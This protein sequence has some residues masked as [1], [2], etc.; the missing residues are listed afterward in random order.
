M[1]D[2]ITVLDSEVRCGSELYILSEKKL[3]ERIELMKFGGFEESSLKNLKIVHK[4]GNSAIRRQLTNLGLPLEDFDNMLVLADHKRE[5]NPLDSDAHNLATMLLIRDILSENR[6]NTKKEEDAP[7]R[8]TTVR[9]EETITPMRPMTPKD[10]FKARVSETITMN[11][12]LNTLV[13]QA[14]IHRW[15]LMQLHRVEEETDKKPCI[16]CCE[17]LDSRTKNTLLMNQRVAKE[18]EYILSHTTVAKVISMVA[19]RREIK[20]VLEE[21]LGEYGQSIYVMP[22]SRYV[23]TDKPLSFWDLS[24]KASANNDILIGYQLVSQR[25]PLVLNPEKK[26]TPIRWG[27][28]DCVIIICETTSLYRKNAADPNGLDFRSPVRPRYTKT[29]TDRYVYGRKD[30]SLSMVLSDENGDV[31]DDV[32]D[33]G[34]DI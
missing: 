29:E 4:F 32:M 9:W 13:H 7:A 21:L 10:R 26:E 33:T 23:K 14:M 11:R 25:G 5:I 6:Y 30:K 16:I 19:M 24:L 1:E 2:I 15:N 27:R 3:D 18:A 17:I 22:V 12:S 34:C 20:G 31:G 28:T 8:T